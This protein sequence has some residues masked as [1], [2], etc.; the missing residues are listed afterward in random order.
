MGKG[1]KIARQRNDGVHVHRSVKI[2]M[3]A[4]AS[5]IPG[6]NG[7]KYSPHAKFEVEPTWVD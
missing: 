6:S 2:R 1:R 4:H 7:K 5:L 3:E